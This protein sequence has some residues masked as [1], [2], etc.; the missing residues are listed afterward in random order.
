M[1]NHLSGIDHAIVGVRDLE[2]ARATFTRLGFQLTPLARHLGRGTGDHCLMLADDYVELCGIVDP[3]EGSESLE[4]FLAAG[5]GLWALALRTADPEGTRAAWEDAGL[6]PAAIAETSRIVEPD[7]ETG[8]RDVVLDTSVTGGV[9]LFACAQLRPEAL[10]RREWQDHP[11]GV[12]GIGSVTVVVAEPSAFVEPMSKV[13]GATCLTET[14]DTLAVHTGRHIVL[15]ATPDD[16]DMLHPGVESSISPQPGPA[17]QP[18]LAVLT[19]VVPD[20]ATTAAVLDRH[21]VAYRQD[22]SGA[23]NIAPEY[24]HG[25]ILEFVAG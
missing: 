14:D 15:F 23:I 25:V 24:S 11:N 3:A 8:C 10:H 22:L 4:R 12:R 2:Q 13:F 19:L 20:L 16:L 18:T 5:E 21:D 6:A 1:A 17:E 7:I 9:P